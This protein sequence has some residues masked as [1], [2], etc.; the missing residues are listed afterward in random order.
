MAL[1]IIHPNLPPINNSFL[2]IAFIYLKKLAILI[3]ILSLLIAIFSDDPFFDTLIT[4]LVGL[5][6][7][8]IPIWVVGFLFY[9][10]IT[11]AKVHLHC[12]KAKEQYLK[13]HGW[14]VDF[15]A[16]GIVIDQKQK[17]VA[18][19]IS[20]RDEVMVCDFHTIRSWHSG[21]NQVTYDYKNQDN[22]YAGSRT[23]TTS[24]YINMQVA[25]AQHPEHGFLVY[26]DKEQSMWMARLNA[27]FNG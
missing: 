2:S 6:F 15:S 19:T 4:M 11:T 16:I 25:D 8:G 1:E 12:H 21:S 27:I 17:K 26:S 18:F 3:V 24:R 13:E 10:A 14:Q 9:K 7:F 20:S 23:R 22:A 5:S